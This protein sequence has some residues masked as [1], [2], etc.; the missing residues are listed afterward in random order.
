MCR[1][2]VSD[3]LLTLDC[4]AQSLSCICFTSWTIATMLNNQTMR[5]CVP[6][7]NPIYYYKKWYCLY[8]FCLDC[9]S[10]VHALF[11]R[12]YL[13][14]QLRFCWTFLGTVLL[15]HIFWFYMSAIMQ[16]K[17]THILWSCQNFL[18]HILFNYAY[19]FFWTSQTYSSYWW[20]IRCSDFFSNYAYVLACQ[21]CLND[22]RW[23]LLL[24]I[25][26]IFQAYVLCLSISLFWIVGA[27]IN[28]QPT[29]T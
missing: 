19:N 3:F 17:S 22:D 20:M 10:F 14:C 1:I 11:S 28:L 6:F 12:R 25:V 21:H 4:C 26:W 24:A 13:L 9:L 18:S 8:L 5:K 29:R 23:M 15:K 2:H 27:W 16:W 7:V